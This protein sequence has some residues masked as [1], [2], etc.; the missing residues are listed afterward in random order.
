[1]KKSNPLRIHIWIFIMA[2]PLLLVSC[3]P[4]GPEVT[5][6][7]DIVGTM[8][9]EEFDFNSVQTYAMPDTVIHIV[10][11]DPKDDDIDRSQD[12]LMLNT[13][14]ANMATLGYQEIPADPDTP[15]DVVMLITA[16]TSTNQGAVYN[17]GW[18]GN[19]GWWPG[20]GGYPGYPGWG[21]GWGYYYPWG[22]P[23]TYS[24]STGSLF[25]GMLDPENTDIEEETLAV[26]WLASMNGLLQGNKDKGAQRIED[27]INQAFRQSESY[28]KRN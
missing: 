11:E 21:P 9:D 23:A 19:W 14:R 7:L 17:P 15:A 26:A 16:M 24:Y 6:D 10:G 25:I 20:W 4:G 28:L 8:Y 18:W 1:M 2:M 22:Y 12:E 27:G 13:V 5:E 3:Y